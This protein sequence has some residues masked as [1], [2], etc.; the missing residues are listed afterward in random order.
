MRRGAGS[1]AE[2]GDDELAWA[3]QRGSA[4]VDRGGE[5]RPERGRGRSGDV[6]EDLRCEARQRERQAPGAGLGAGGQHQTDAV[7]EA[8]GVAGDELDRVGACGVKQRIGR[9][10][11]R[12]VGH[13]NASEVAGSLLHGGGDMGA[14]IVFTGHDRAEVLRII[15]HGGERYGLVGGAPG[16]RADDALHVARREPRPAQ[17]DIRASED[18]LISHS[19]QSCC[20]R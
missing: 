17:R 3:T 14:H 18:P 16:R 1:G 9:G 5:A 2:G 6:V 13:A 10:Y 20:R 4:R 19:V 12:A 7:A 15:S 8:A 11:V